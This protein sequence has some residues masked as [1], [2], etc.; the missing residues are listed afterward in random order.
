MPLKIFVDFTLPPNAFKLLQEG[1][2]DH[3]LVFPKAPATSVLAK[4]SWDPAFALVDVAFGQPDPEA[5]QKTEKLRLIQISSS[6]IT[7]YD[8]PQFRHLVADK[9]VAVCNAASVYSEQC[10][11]HALSFILAQAR[12]LPQALRTRVAG[13]SP[14]WNRLR[15]SCI[16]LEGQ[17]VLIVGYGAIGKRLG[18]MLKPLNVNV[19]AYRRHPAQNEAVR[20]IGVKELDHVLSQQADHIVNILPDSAETRHFFNRAKFSNVKPGAIFYNIGRGGTVDQEALL[21]ALRSKR[22]G[23]AWLDVTDPEPL[24]D[25]HPLYEE[26]NCYITP[27]VAGG[28]NDESEKLVR[29]FLNNLKRFVNSEALVDRVM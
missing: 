3:E 23:A 7:R 15:S 1:T 29:H 12:M 20:V 4:S 6:G 17:T 27:H 8:N 16:G 2:K 9:K 11:L 25:S 5:V 24:P 28:E 13:G 26:P 10:A 21:G 18:D 19:V 22:L 14:E